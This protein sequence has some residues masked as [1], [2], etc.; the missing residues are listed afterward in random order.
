MNF[1]E[2]GLFGQSPAM[3]A[4]PIAF[5]FRFLFISIIL[6]VV[7]IFVARL[8]AWALSHVVGISIGLQIGGLASLRNVEVKLNKGAVELVSIGEIKLRLRKSSVK[9]GAGVSKNPKLELSI[10]N[11]QIVLRVSK[12]KKGTSK[13]TQKT[14]KNKPR[15]SGKGKGKGKWKLIANIARFFSLSLTKFVLKVAMPYYDVSEHC[16]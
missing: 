16:N 3:V 12:S 14:K 2:K 6:W 10:C 8:L 1:T 5:L 7:F 4:S 11:L 13:R 15:S 9:L